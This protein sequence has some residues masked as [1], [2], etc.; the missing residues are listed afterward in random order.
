MMTIRINYNKQIRPMKK[1][2][3][4]SII[5]RLPMETCVFIL[6]HNSNIP[7]DNYYHIFIIHI[8]VAMMM[9]ALHRFYLFYARTI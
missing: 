7:T 1:S 8:I 9:M 6:F 3:H 2:V 5:I 4:V